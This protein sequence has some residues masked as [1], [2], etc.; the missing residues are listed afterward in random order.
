[1]RIVFPLTYVENGRI[2]RGEGRITKEVSLQVVFSEDKVFSHGDIPSQYVTLFS[3][4][5]KVLN[6]YRL[7]PLLKNLPNKIQVKLAF[8]EPLETFLLIKDS[9]VL[10]NEEVIKKIPVTELYPLLS[11]ALLYAFKVITGKPYKE[12]LREVLEIYSIYSMQEKNLVKKCL[13]YNFLD[14]GKVFQF[15]LEKWSKKPV[16]KE[17]RRLLTWIY[18]Q[19]RRDYPY[20]AVATREILEEYGDRMYTSECQSKLYQIIRT[21]YKEDL[22][23]ENIKRLIKEA[24]ERGEITVFMRLGRASMILGHLLSASKRVESSNKLRELVT[25][26]QK[27]TGEKDVQ[28]L[29]DTVSI[30]RKLVEA[31]DFSKAKMTRFLKILL[32]ELN[33]YRD[34]QEKNINRKF[35]QGKISLEDVEKELKKLNDICNTIQ[36]LIYEIKDEV[37]KSPQK[38]AV[39]IIFGQRISPRGAAR[40]A[41]INEVYKAYAGPDYGLG[42]YIIEGGENVYATPSLAPL[43]YVDYWIEALPLFIYETEEG[44]YEINVMSIQD[45]KGAPGPHAI[46]YKNYLTSA[47]Q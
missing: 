9:K 13:S 31:K 20:D 6:K 30:I 1:M 23:E 4:A 38:P 18:A 17:K 8:S 44:K 3:E 43:K 40:I 28:E 19:I 25:Q 39:F 14:K 5:F 47:V 15:L 35:E 33:E 26:L 46:S 12:A 41:Y 42:E 32:E 7:H 2:F 27:F 45:S 11:I 29:K 16:D 37:R 22:E 36:A 21:S 34:K 10:L 24:R